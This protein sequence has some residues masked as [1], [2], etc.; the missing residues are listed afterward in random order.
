MIDFRLEEKASENKLI[1]WVVKYFTPTAD[2]NQQTVTDALRGAQA[3][4]VTE[5]MP[6]ILQHQGHS[7]TIIGYEA[8]KSGINLLLFDP[9]KQ[10]ARP[11]LSQSSFIDIINRTIKSAI[12]K[13]A[14]F[15]TSASKSSYPSPTKLSSKIKRGVLHPLHGLKPRKRKASD[16]DPKPISSKRARS[17]P[18]EVIVIEDSDEEDTSAHAPVVDSNIDVTEVYKDVLAFSRVNAKSLGSVFPSFI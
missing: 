12:K 15:K 11:V 17:D 8:T 10:V 13:A 1:D 3:V 16:P 2:K 6:I 5:R 7:R 14:S 4:T 18:H 9:S